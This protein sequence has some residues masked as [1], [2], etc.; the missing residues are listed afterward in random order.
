MARLSRLLRA[1]GYSLWFSLAFVFFVWITFPWNRVR[2]QLVVAADGAGLALHA[3]SMGSALVGV[4][5]RGMSLGAKAEQGKEPPPPWIRFDQVRLRAGAVGLVS[6]ALAARKVLAAGGVTAPEV[7]RQLLAALGEAQLDGVL[8][9]GPFDIRAQGDNPEAVKVLVE[10]EDLDLSQAPLEFGA[11][12]TQ[13]TGKLDTDADVLWHW[14]D[15][16][17][18]SGNI[19]ILFKGLILDN[20]II[21]GFGLGRAEFGHAEAHVR[22]SRGR[23]EFRD[24]VFDSDVV[25]ARV[26]GFIT[27]A[28]NLPL[29]RLA[30]RVRFKVSDELDPLIK[31]IMG[32]GARHRDKE[33]W[34]HYQ[35]HGTLKRPRFRASRT[36]A[37][38]S[39]KPTTGER[40]P[41]GMDREDQTPGRDDRST[42]ERRA[43]A[44]ERRDRLRQERLKRREE[45]QHTRQELMERRKAEASE[46]PTVPSDAE[47]EAHVLPDHEGFEGT[48]EDAPDQDS[49]PDGEI[50]EGEAGGEGD[51]EDELIEDE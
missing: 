37:S 33:G 39:K 32:S 31:G 21:K 49:P 38:R 50:Q 29:S 48:E 46:A 26:E 19:D 51:V 17:N 43:E 20:L 47:D 30:L 10:A 34:Y 14:D 3:D 42:E 18:S 28:R 41:A 23:A 45:R 4:K 36:A 35:A 40:T 11:F 27:V 25:Q 16:K 6:T 8:Y 22:M 44:K 24:T 9:G 2:D 13:A 1:G 7:S 15:P 5:A 12:S